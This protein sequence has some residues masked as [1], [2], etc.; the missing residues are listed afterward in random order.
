MEFFNGLLPHS[1]TKLS[2]LNQYTIPWMRKIVLNRYGP[3]RC[4]VID[5]FAGKGRYDDESSGSPL[6]LINNAI[7][8]CEQARKNKWADPTILIFLNEMDVQNYLLLQ[9]NVSSLGF[10][11]QGDSYYRSEEYETIIIKVENKSFK[12]FM[13]DILS[14]INK[15]RTL[16]PSFCFVDPF[17]F[18]TTPFSL[19]VD[20]LKNENSEILLNFIY[21]ETNRFINHPNK[22]IQEQISKHMGLV[23]LNAI[24]D[25]IR[26]LAPIDRK[27]LIVKTYSDSILTQTNATF[28]SN[29]EVKKNGRTK[30]ILFHITK[31][32]NG[33]KLMKETMWKHDETGTYTY[34]ARNNLRQL[35]FEQ[36]LSKDKSIHIE[37][38]SS[39]LR[40]E[41]SGQKKVCMSVLEEFILIET[42]YP[43]SNFLRP[44]LK[45]LEEKGLID[46]FIGRTKRKTYPEKCRMDFL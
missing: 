3:R 19:F 42:I 38:L 13:T 26:E 6:I 32:I 23:N 21:E 36:I 4:L 31:N 2:I 22:K 25:G 43:I 7:G 39:I 27:K 17:G 9:E 16:I 29:F 10:V 24:T 40:D 5:G 35:D 37:E 18:S 45:I 28:V 12:K 44:A 41:F 1:E 20:Y 11:S 15:N 46:S 8:F 33:L 30:M 34:D 14:Q